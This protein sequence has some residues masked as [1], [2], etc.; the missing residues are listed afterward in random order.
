MF[1]PKTWQ[2]NLRYKA[3]GNS[4]DYIIIMLKTQGLKNS[5]LFLDFA[6]EGERV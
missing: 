6:E 3:I 1:L 2:E 5:T 4:K